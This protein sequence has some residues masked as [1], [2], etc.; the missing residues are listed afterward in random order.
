MLVGEAAGESGHQTLAGK[1]HAADLGIGCGR[2]AGKSGTSEN[3]VQIR[4]DFFERKIIVLVAVGAAGLVE[5]LPFLLLRG[6]CGL[7]VAAGPEAPCAGFT[8]LAAESA[9]EVF[10]LSGS[11][12]D[13][14]WSN[15]SKSSDS[16]S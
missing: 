5:V 6:Q 7:A 9:L 16:D 12:V 2:A 13:S 14:N 3:R 8:S 15:P 11:S 4:R 1:D 10:P